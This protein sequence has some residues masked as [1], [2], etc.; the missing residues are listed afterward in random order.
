MGQVVELP[1]MA[2]PPAGLAFRLDASIRA[3]DPSPGAPRWTVLGLKRVYYRDDLPALFTRSLALDK[4]VPRGTVLSWIFTGDQGG[5][6]VELSSDSVT[7]RQRYY[8]SIGV[9]SQ[10]PP[11]E[12]YPQGNWSEDKVQFQG[13]AHLVTVVLDNELALRVLVNGKQVVR[14]T[15]LMEVRRQQITWDPAAGDKTSVLDG[16][17]I[18]P[19]AVA[20]TISVHSENK[21]QTVLGF[22]GSLS[23]PAYAQLSDEGKQR[24]WKLVSEYNLLIQ[25]EYPT[26]Q[27]LKSDLSNFDHLDDASAHYYGDNFPNGEVS[28]FQYLKHIHSIG[29]ETI[30]E[31][32]QLPPWAAQ[33]VTGADGK[34]AE[35]VDIDAYVRAVVGYCKAAHKASG[36]PPDIVGVQNEIVQSAETWKEMILRLRE[37]LDQAGF[38]TVKIQ[39]PDATS[40]AVGVHTAETI[41]G[42]PDAWKDIDFAAAHVYDYQSFFEHPDGYDAVMKQFRSAIGTKPLLVTEFAV[43]RPAY[44]SGSYRVAFAMAQLYHKSMTILDAEMLLYCWTLLDVEEPSF[45]ATRSLFVPDRDNG[46]V[47]K[48]SSFQLRA[49]GAF[50]RRI[51]K[52]MVRVD[53]DSGDAG[54]LV[55]AYEGSAGRRTM[56]VLNRSTEPRLLQV[57]WPGSSVPVVEVSS[58]Y[59]ANQVLKPSPK[60]LVLQP[61]EIITLSNVGLLQ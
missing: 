7:V 50:S 27:H 35:K 16:R 29:G 9:S 10:R 2:A 57:D 4:G 13:D 14:Q 55:S 52:G 43:N 25:R 54:L 20:A 23:V 34:R 17:L 22:G 31:F 32:W 40:L 19:A 61:G 45:G 47:P 5:I 21:H 30:F 44:Q 24:W 3:P 28:D 53:A 38:M 15:C 26:G 59:A 1:E 49:Y 42:M 60:G 6:T 33:S 56:I 58:P 8:D 41:S 51:R 46:Y 11:K 12:A 18:A 36:Y 37:G 48:P 39:M